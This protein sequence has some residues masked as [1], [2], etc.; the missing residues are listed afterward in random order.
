MLNAYSLCDLLHK[1]SNPAPQ[2]IWLF[3]RFC[4]C[5]LFE[6]MVAVVEQTAQF[7]W[8]NTGPPKPFIN[9]SNDS[10]YEVKIA[11]FRQT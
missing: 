7:S 2:I 9:M 1:S 4:P 10:K 11:E 8:S 5:R 6:V 3:S